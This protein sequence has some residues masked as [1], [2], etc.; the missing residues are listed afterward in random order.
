MLLAL[1][2][3]SGGGP[4]AAATLRL[5]VTALPIQLGNPYHS[6]GVPGI[7]VL[8]AIFDALTN[9]GP[10]GE[11][12]PWLATEWNA[13]TPTRWVFKLRPG[14][15][16]SNGVPFTADAVV[17]AT[18]FLISPDAAGERTAEEFTNVSGAEARDALTVVFTLRAPDV[19]FPRAVSMLNVVE[20]GA[21]S[22]LGREEFAKHPVGTGPFQVQAWKPAAATLTAFKG[23]WRAPKVDALEVLALPDATSRVQGLLSER[24]DLAMILGPD[25]TDTVESAGHR[26]LIYPLGGVMGLAFITTKDKTPVKDVR[27]RRA[28]NYAVDKERIVKVLLNGAGKVSGQPA[29]RTGFGHNASVAA[30]PYDPAKAKALLAEAG[31]PNGLSL[32]LESVPGTIAADAQVFEQVAADL[33]RV[34]VTLTIRVT[35]FPTFSRHYRQGGWDGD[36]FGMYYNADPTLDPLRGIKGHSC[37]SE[38]PWFC[39]ATIMPTFTA[40]LGAADIAT[41]ARLTAEIMARYHDQAQSLFLFEVSGFMGLAARVKD[42]R[43]ANNFMYLHEVTLTGGP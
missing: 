6:N 29:T 30:Y 39:D 20:P 42:F 19:L 11:P 21:W 28:L 17:N 3:L 18:K 4:V 2:G 27:V 1:L 13:E 9:I 15:T 16:F 33:A 43:I 38:H 26:M 35:T 24:I 36:A 5:A 25:S 31:Y 10:D 40:A 14:V 32:M 41:R 37:F 23:S 12:R 22:R 34:G 7:F 8:N